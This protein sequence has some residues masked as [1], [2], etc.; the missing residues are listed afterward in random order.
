M[1][2]V[3][4]IIYN[5]Q[6]RSKE[7]FLSHFQEKKP[8]MLTPCLDHLP[9]PEREKLTRYPQSISWPMEISFAAKL[10]TK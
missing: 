1:S 10:G 9:S 8:V 6:R 4:H 5:T 7:Q 2:S 3:P